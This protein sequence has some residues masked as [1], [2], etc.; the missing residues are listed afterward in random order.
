[1]TSRDLGGGLFCRLLRMGDVL[2]NYTPRLSPHS[3]SE[4]FPQM[5]FIILRVTFFSTLLNNLQNISQT[6]RLPEP[7]IAPFIDGHL[8]S[9][10]VVLTTN[11]DGKRST[12][13][14]SVSSRFAGLVFAL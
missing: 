6:F 11:H 2:L 9:A 13:G 3:A 7:S 12:D 5:C 10:D 14:S 4:H 8:D 1:M